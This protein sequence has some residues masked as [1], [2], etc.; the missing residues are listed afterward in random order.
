MSSQ[1]ASHGNL[2]QIISNYLYIHNKSNL[3]KYN[4][5]IVTHRKIL[6]LMHNTLILLTVP[7]GPKLYCVYIRKP[8]Q[9][10]WVITSHW[11]SRGKNDSL[12]IIKKTIGQHNGTVFRRSWV[13]LPA[14]VFLKADYNFLWCIYS[15]WVLPPTFQNHTCQVNW[16]Q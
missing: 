4:P 10:Y 14:D 5:I 2:V 11:A 9:L 16:P 3:Y 7:V 1:G 6:S 13:C 8:R 12:C 15:F